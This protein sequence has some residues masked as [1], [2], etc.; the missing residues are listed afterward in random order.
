MKRRILSFLLAITLLAVL[1]PQPVIA[2]SS[3]PEV[4]RLENQICSTYKAALRSS[5][6]KSFDGYCA[7]MVNW[8]VYFL[9]INAERYG[10][11]GKDEYDFYKRMSITTGGFRV[12][13]YS[14]S[15]YNLRD[16][17]NAIT[18]N[19]TVDAY[20]ILVGFQRTNT[21]A[22]RKYGHAMLIHGIV[23]GQ[24]YF[25]ESFDATFNGKYYAEGK[26]ISC[27]IDTFYKFYSSWATYEGIIY[28]GLKN[29][30]QACQTFPTNY[31]AMAMAPVD[32]YKEPSDPG[33]YEAEPL[34][35]GIYAGEILLAE[36]LLKTP[37]GGYW[38]QLRRGNQTIYARADKFSFVQD[39]LSDV[40]V[41]DLKLP[42]I[43]AKSA[44]FSLSGILRPVNTKL[45][46][47]NVAVYSAEDRTT[48][49]FSGGV[50]AFEDEVNLSA[51]AL[52]KELTFRK[53]AK[54][55]Y[56]LEITAHTGSFRF[57]NGT[58]VE[59]PE[60]KVIYQSQ[61]QV[62]S[63][64]KSY[65]NLSFE[66]N[67]GAAE[68]Q[69]IAFKKGEKVETLP[70]ATRPGY[71]F[72]GW[73]L[74]PEGNEPAEIGMTVSKNTVFY[75]QWE[76][77]TQVLN[78]W[79]LTDAG[80]RYYEADVPVQGW[81]TDG[82]IRFYQDENGMP[83]KGWKELGDIWYYFSDCGSSVTG[84]QRID[85]DYYYFLGDGRRVT[86]WITVNQ[87]QLYFDVDGKFLPEY[88]LDGKVQ[89]QVTV[90]QPHFDRHVSLNGGVNVGCPEF[91]QPSVMA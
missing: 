32:A 16:A 64:T 60:E 37:G 27:S 3:N 79:Q 86:G 91:Y 21:T 73:T 50:D 75:A 4:T 19:G 5:G 66:G 81:F 13:S 84:W 44:S 6:R 58:H 80:W 20:N 28:F 46:H 42:S 35:Q 10:C 36:N 62:V 63:S 48:P 88:K 59:Y 30:A 31:Y 49:L 45:Y 34:E 12:R 15:K 14:A 40:S 55:T 39:C 74:D 47:A 24:V 71:A 70:L 90:T 22:G 56:Y 38:Y 65:V 61:F 76:K 8:M 67:G 17:L 78:G 82:N 7:S 11:D 85:D 83:V 18:L 25:A 87:D 57:E 41:S 43:I 72:K 33:I 26:P 69:R 29:Y 89:Y 54:G 23:D 2:S 68:I 53:L 1:F 52:N 51:K 9:G 77:V